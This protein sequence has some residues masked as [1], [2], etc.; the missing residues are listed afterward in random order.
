MAIE[1]VLE[2][3]DKVSDKA[4]S[5]AD[6]MDGMVGPILGVTAAIGAAFAAVV[7]GGAAMALEASEAKQRMT[8]MFDALGGGVTT[9]KA[10]IAMM[11]EL[12]SVTGQTR[13]QMAPM[14][15]DLMAM[16][17]TQLPALRQAL[18]AAASSE[19]LM[20]AE[21]KAAFETITKKVQEAI[22]AHTGL[23]MADKQLAQLAS[24]GVNVAD[25]AMKMGLT[26]NQLRNQ[27]KAGT[28]DA[29]EF[30]DAMQSA[31]ID[32]GAGPLAR[33]AGSLGAM[34]DR[35]KQSITDMF[36][37][38]DAGPFLDA[39]KD[40]LSI[41][42]AGTA[43]G[44]TMKAAITGFFNGVFK[45]AAVVIPYIKLFFENLIIWALK[46][47]IF[48]KSHWDTIKIIFKGVGVVA[49]MVL[50][51]MAVAAAIVIA[52]FAAMAAAG[53]AIASALGFVIGKIYEFI[54]G[55]GKALSD[56]ANSAVDI[57]SNFVQ[58]LVQG[59]TNGVGAVVDAAKNLAKGAMDSVKKAL[60]IASPSKIM[61]QLG[62]HTAGGFAQGIASG[63]GDV[64]S[65]ASGMGGA[66]ASGAAAAPA[67]SSGGGG[68]TVNVGGITINGAGSSGEA[69][70][71]T[72]QQ[73][74]RV[75]ERL[76]LTQGLG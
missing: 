71:L 73:V 13:E 26:A 69:L 67:A 7:I 44:Q 65:A 31:L 39:M 8:T 58:G 15:K 42:G 72:E 45:A 1:I 74:S 47:Y 19:A 22:V 61:M 38:V 37:D 60:G 50:G 43:S 24:T 21:G 53:L 41:F 57:A 25:V 46:A 30:G 54:G 16:G 70:A 40:L 59:I 27:L 14:A 62:G 63:T 52:P 34:W 48:L 49:V 4:S 35:F 28:V 36:A 51:A 3:V 56:W 17:V 12:G 29:K 64:A 20:G 66:A 2:A 11:N 33:M 9:G 18:L 32:K 55:A 23:K 10:T 75:F 6:S 68:V 5:I 76:V